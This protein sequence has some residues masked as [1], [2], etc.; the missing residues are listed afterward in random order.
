MLVLV[1]IPNWLYDAM[2]KHCEPVY[3]QSL[4]DAVRDGIPLTSVTAEIGQLRSHSARFR[5]SDGKVV[6]AD[7]QNIF[8]ILG[9]IGKESED[10]HE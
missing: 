3:S 10:K 6:Y 4:G 7:S 5:T 8:D 9:K 2:M 1:D